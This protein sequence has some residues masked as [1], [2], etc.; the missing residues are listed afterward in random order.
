MKAC[1]LAIG[2]L[3]LTPWTAIRA[4]LNWSELP[5]LPDALGLGGPIVG[6]QGDALIVAG[7]ANFPAGPPWRDGDRPAGVKV[8]HDRIFVLLPG[9]DQWL[10]AGRLP[11][12]LAYAA[13]VS[14]PSGLLVLGGETF[15]NSPDRATAANYPVEEVLRLSWDAAT[16]QVLVE[17]E[18]LPPLPRASHYHAAGQIGDQLYV[19]AS[20][21]AAATSRR[22]DE[23]SF[24]ALD[25]KA[26]ASQWVSLPPWPGAPRE[27]MAVAVQAAGADD[28][29]ASPRCLFMFSGGTWSKDAN[30]EPDLSRFEYFTDNY[31]FEPLSGQWTRLADLPSLPESRRIELQGYRWE[32]GRATWVA[33]DSSTLR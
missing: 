29:Y 33:D 2:L 9:E 18:A 27:Q 7:G 19:T 20:H 28:H 11:Y 16:Q 12:P 22:L 8:W 31:R 14:G 17:R 3:L 10:D 21:A 32:A 24:W 1:L 5:P 23:K 30:G 25:T 4:E 15:G 13:T 6:V 26:E